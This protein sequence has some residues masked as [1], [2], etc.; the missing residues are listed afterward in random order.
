MHILKLSAHTLLMSLSGTTM[1]LF[2]WLGLR[3]FYWMQ[4]W[5]CLPGCIAVSKELHD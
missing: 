3:T 4:P 1:S 5:G 2:P